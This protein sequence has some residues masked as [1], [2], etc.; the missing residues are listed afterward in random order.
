MNNDWLERRRLRRSLKRL[1]V[2]KYR[3]ALKGEW[4]D[5]DNTIAHRYEQESAPMRARLWEMESAELVGRAWALGIVVADLEPLRFGNPLW[6]EEAGCR[7]LS[8]EGRRAIE[9]S[10]SAVRREQVD[11]W[12]RRLA[13]ITGIIGALTGLLAVLL[14]KR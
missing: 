4:S 6:R 9:R 10:I 1:Y 7:Y 12:F 14:S 2:T 11:M 3:E 13:P 8:A 5:G